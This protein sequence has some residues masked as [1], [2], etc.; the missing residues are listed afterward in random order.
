M[1]NFSGLI[2]KPEVFSNTETLGLADTNIS[3]LRIND[4]SAVKSASDA[5]RFNL[6]FDGSNSNLL[7]KKDNTGTVSVI[8]SGTFVSGTPSYGQVYDP[9][10]N[11]DNE[12]AWI[13]GSGGVLDVY[14]W[15]TGHPSVGEIGNDP[16]GNNSSD[17]FK[18]I[19]RNTSDVSLVVGSAGNKSSGI[20]LTQNGTY[21]VSYNGVWQGL[22][23]GQML[24]QLGFGISNVN[25]GVPTTTCFSTIKTANNDE[26]IPASG[27]EV[28][29]ITGA[30][31]ST[32]VVIKP[33]LRGVT[34][35]ADPAN[36]SFAIRNQSMTVARVSN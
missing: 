24:F 10:E 27:S 20:Q 33:W 21:I 9:A 4:A 19:Y 6:F 7:S 36:L 11:S 18:Q 32:P 25:G 29:N 1:S 14:P 17:W 22:F 30:S 15:V 2:G 23:G 26:M 31:P 3:A 35:G 28:I 34:G 5:N 13:N 16:N 12:W 8:E